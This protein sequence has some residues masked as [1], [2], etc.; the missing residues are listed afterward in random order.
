[1]T[2]QVTLETL[3]LAYSM[4]MDSY[5]QS[6]TVQLRSGTPENEINLEYP[7]FSDV[8]TKSDEIISYISS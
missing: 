3:K 7:T 8:T 2:E 1:M 5:H 6:F 4:L